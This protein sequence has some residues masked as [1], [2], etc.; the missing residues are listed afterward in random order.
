MLDPS[1]LGARQTEDII[2]G[3]RNKTS[4]ERLKHHHFC[5][6]FGFADIASVGCFLSLFKGRK[7]NRKK[8]EKSELVIHIQWSLSSHYINM[9]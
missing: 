7:R 8:K 4:R 1:A 6:S 9:E 2:P 3:F 5:T